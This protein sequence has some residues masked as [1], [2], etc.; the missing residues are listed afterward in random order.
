M[1]HETLSPNFNALSPAYSIT[2]HQ[3]GI[4][5]KERGVWMMVPANDTTQQWVWGNEIVIGY[6][7]EEFELKC[8]AQ[9]NFAGDG[10]P[11]E[12]EPD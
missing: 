9:H 1:K 12:D 5:Q 4:V 10:D 7:R 6:A 2:V 8:L 3:R 11:T